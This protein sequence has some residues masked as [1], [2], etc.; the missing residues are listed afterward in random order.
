MPFSTSSGGTITGFAYTKTQTGLN[1][2]GVSFD[3]TLVVLGTG[4]INQTPAGLGIWGGG[5]NKVSNGQRLFFGMS[6]SNVSG[7]TV[8]FDGFTAVD[9]N[10][11]GPNDTGVLSTDPF[12]VTT[13]NNF[14]TSTTG[15]NIVDISAESPTSFFAIAGPANPPGDPLNDFRIGGVLASFT[16][17]AAVPE[18][19]AFLFGSL[20]A[21]SVG[22]VAL[23]RRPARG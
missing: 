20:V 19:T 12:L 1:A 9:F 6:V 3:A 5:S 7:G 22:M 8:S 2:D 11:F 23:R 4:L 17:M 18:P 13:A 10:R 14:F 16:G 21:G 15:G